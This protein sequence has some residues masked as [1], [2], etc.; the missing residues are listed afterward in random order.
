[1]HLEVNDDV[2]FFLASNISDPLTSNRARIQIR[3]IRQINPYIHSIFVYNSG[4]G[5]YISEGE[6]GFDGDGFIQQDETFHK[7]AEGN[8]AI[9]LTELKPTGSSPNFLTNRTMDYVISMEYTNRT[10]NG[11]QH[12]VVINLDE[13]LFVR[14]YL[15]K[16]GDE[17]LIADSS[18]TFWPIPT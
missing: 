10:L 9:Y 3:N 5:E 17:L 16:S 2:H 15:Q 8:R 7:S 12:S 1:M 13:D 4:S 18:G 6:P 14:D 11:E